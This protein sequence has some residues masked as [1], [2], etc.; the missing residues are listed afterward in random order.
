MTPPRRQKHRA[1]QLPN[2]LRIIGG[3]WRGMRIDFPADRGDPALAGSR[4]RDAVQLAAAADRRRA[5]P[6][7]V[8]GQ[9]RAGHRSAVARRGGGDVRRSRAAGRPASARRRCERL[10]QPRAT[11][12]SRGRDCASWQRPPQPFDIVFLDPP[13]AS[14]LLHA[15][16]RQVGAGLAGAGCA[17]STSS[18]RRTRRCRRCQPAGRVHRTKQA[19]QVGYHLLRARRPHPPLKRIRHDRRHVS[20]HVRPDHQRPP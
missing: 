12:A 3:R 14:T 15:V 11:V 8:R 17:T 6:G 10:G 18:A 2:R 4:A 13:F 16:V 7:S 1:R 5:L 20:R 19:G 9:R